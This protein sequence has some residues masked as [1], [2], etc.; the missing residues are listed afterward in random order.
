MQVE[1]WKNIPYKI[2]LVSFVLLALSSCRTTR[3]VVA[4]KEIKPMAAEKV[5]RRV[6]KESPRYTTYS[7]KKIN[8]ELN[9]KGEKNSFAAQFK[10]DHDDKMIVTIRKMSVPVG[11][12]LITRDSL[13]VVDYYDKNYIVDE[14]STIQKLLGIDVDFEIL[15][16][17]LTADI[18][19]LT[20]EDI[21]N[22]ELASVIESDMYRIDTEFNRKIKQALSKGSDRRMN[23]YM[24]KMEDHEFFDISMWIDPDRFVLR[25]LVLK[26]IKYGR[27]ITIYY[28]KFETVGKSLFPQ[29]ISLEYKDKKNSAS[30][31]MDIDKQSIND[32]NDFSFNIPDKF[33]KYKPKK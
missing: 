4:P 24:R 18:A 5:L 27:D 30:L 21:F 23:R 7:A 15:Q 29:K 33:E 1:N 9:A 14:I 22:K 19:S 6:E 16:T 12:A 3:T 10:I 13:K 32:D 11:R 28:D 2:L 17:L 25:K 8:V 20:G 31:Q 26:D